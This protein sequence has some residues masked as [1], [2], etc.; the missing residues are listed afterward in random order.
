[1]NKQ[2]KVANVREDEK[3]MSFVKFTVKA[4]TRPSGLELSSMLLRF[5][6][7]KR[8]VLKGIDENLLPGATILYR[9]SALKG[10]TSGIA[11][12]SLVSAIVLL[13]ISVVVPEA[14]FNIIVIIM[15]FTSMNFLAT[16]MYLMAKIFFSQMKY[17][18]LIKAERGA[19]IAGEQS[20]NIYNRDYMIGLFVVG[21]PTA[22]CFLLITI[23]L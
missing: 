14:L 5:F 21:L 18:F 12:Y 15:A 19:E 13:I 2:E 10:M 7:Y 9:Y 3:K 17:E 6:I 23:I 11:L 1:M 8:I 20:H 4:I 16:S 22:I